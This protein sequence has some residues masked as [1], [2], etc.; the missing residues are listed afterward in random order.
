MGA[1]PKKGPFNSLFTTIPVK[2]GEYAR[3]LLIKE[4]EKVLK[5]KLKIIQNRGNHLF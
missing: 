5:K 1:Y 3:G 4:V 2:R